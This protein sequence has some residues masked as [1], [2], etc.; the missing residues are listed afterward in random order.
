MVLTNQD[1]QVLLHQIADLL[2]LSDS[3]SFRIRAY[4]QAAHTVGTLEENAAL[5]ILSEQIGNLPGIGPT[6]SKCL[7]EFTTTGTCSQ[8]VDLHKKF[9]AGLLDLQKITGLGPKRIKS[10]YKNLGIDSLAKLEA[11]CQNNKV[12]E[13]S[14]F[15]KK[16]QKSILEEI[17]VLGETGKYRDR[18][19]VVPVADQLL[20]FVSAISGVTQATIAGSIR[21][22]KP[23]VRDI[24][25]IT[26]TELP[27]AVG[28]LVVSYPE[29]EKILAQGDTKISVR[30]KSGI[31][32]DIRMIMPTSYACALAYFTGSKDFN[33]ALRQLALDKG[34]SL[35]E[36]ILRPLDGATPPS[37]TTEKELHNLLGLTY[38]EPEKRET[39]IEILRQR[40]RA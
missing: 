37:I 27:K 21:R 1:Y 15:G 24:D 5:L 39:A 38:I 4:R 12:E 31:Q 20:T 22:N 11:A 36:Y 19:E 35:N 26:V 8:I 34:Y 40:G 10:L 13:L 18:K 7:Y 32:A 16:L 14:G 28:P 3:N 23:L 30:L 9:P 33:V 25:I 29:V 6:I 2:D 17:A